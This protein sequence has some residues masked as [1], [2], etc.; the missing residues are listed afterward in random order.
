VLTS[1]TGNGEP[2]LCDLWPYWYSSASYGWGQLQGRPISHR[3]QL[4]TRFRSA[5][6]FGQNPAGAWVRR[7]GWYHDFWFTVEARYLFTFN[8]P[9]Q[10]Q[11]SGSNEIFVFINGVLVVDLV[12]SITSFRAA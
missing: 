12:P 1:T 2:L 10:L 5:A 9:F 7:P 4:R 6:W 3:A 8:G 11:F